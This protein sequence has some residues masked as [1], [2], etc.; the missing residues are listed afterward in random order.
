[1]ARK[2][3][4]MNWAERGAWFCWGLAAGILWMR[5][6]YRGIGVQLKALKEHIDNLDKA[7]RE[8]PDDEV[9]ICKACDSGNYANGICPTCGKD[10]KVN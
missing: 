2:G 1:M 7:I 5:W 3:Q 6:L 8:L 4:A 10:G 9:A